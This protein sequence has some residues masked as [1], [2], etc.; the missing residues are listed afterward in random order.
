MTIVHAGN[1]NEYKSLA[2]FETLDAFNEHY[3]KLTYKYAE[4]LDTKPSYKKILSALFKLAKDTCGVAFPKRETLAKEAGCST[5]SV[6]NFIKDASMFGIEI[7]KAV[8]KSGKRLGGWAHNVF[9]FGPIEGLCEL[10]SSPRCEASC[11]AYCEASLRGVEGAQTLVTTGSQEAKNEAE[12]R[13]IKQEIKQESKENNNNKNI[14]TYSDKVGLIEQE[15]EENKVEYVAAQY[16]IDKD[17]VEAFNPFYMSYKELSEVIVSIKR[18]IEKYKW[19]LAECKDAIIEAIK[20]FFPTYKEYM[21]G[22]RRFD[23]NPIAYLCGVIKKKIKS[24][25]A[26]NDEPMDETGFETD[27]IDFFAY[28]QANDDETESNDIVDLF[29]GPLFDAIV[30]KQNEQ[31]I[32]QE[33]EVALSCY[34][35][36]KAVETD[37]FDAWQQAARLIALELEYDDYA[38][39]VVLERVIGPCPSR[40]AFI[41]EDM[42]F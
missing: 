41:D 2:K 27:P 12:T 30:K 24:F 3:R 23:V 31:R 40:T 38:A 34:N 13:L 15:V 8:G 26:T 7:V 28:G 11:E 22:I 17:I 16:S 42:P 33:N 37:D 1:L 25:F 29:S 19:N 18:T 5:R 9:V 35:V 4:L 14:Y 32:E 36:A 6:D 10:P 20:A 39:R 21:Q